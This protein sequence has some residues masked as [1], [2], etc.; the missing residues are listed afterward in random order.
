MT[1][2]TLDQALTLTP[3]EDGV[4]TA[5]VTTDF[6]NG[7]LVMDP[8]KGAPFG[9]LMAAL[10]ARAAREG[11]GITTPLLTLT[12]QYLAGARFE[13]VDFEAT[14]LRGGRNV[15]YASVQA[16]QPGRPAL[17]ALATFGSVNEG[18][19]VK[20]LKPSATPF[21]DLEPDFDDLDPADAPHGFSP[22]WFTRYIERKFDGGHGLF[23]RKTLDDPTLRLWMRATDR[24]PL[25]ELRLCFLLDGIYP[26]Y[27]TVLPYPPIIS[28]SVDLRYDFLEPLTP[29]VSPEG[30]AIFEFT[31]RDVGGGWALDDGI[32]YAPDGR[33]LALAR[34]RRKLAPQLP[35]R[36][37]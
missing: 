1:Q 10:T 8:A 16:G 6:S 33:P 9:G 17:S 30:W 15:S 7:P 31:V 12:V 35:S 34:Q 18:A 21:G 23:A 3:G 20:P 32:A 26:S 19:L 37:A 5:D 22:P 28:A 24:Q 14:M 36:P 27:F 25:D 11:L 13:A 2:Q 4:L 29:D